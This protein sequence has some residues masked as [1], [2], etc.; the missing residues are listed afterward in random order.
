MARGVIT[1]YRVLV[2]DH[3]LS[4]KLEF[5]V[6][7][8]PFLQLHELWSAGDYINLA[9]E[10]RSSVGYNDSLHLDVIHIHQ[11]IRGLYLSFQYLFFLSACGFQ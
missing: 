4:R 1:G 6:T 8:K 7:K 10:A 11:S 3:N 2:V 5:N 9:V